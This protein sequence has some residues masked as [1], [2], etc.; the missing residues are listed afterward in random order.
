MTDSYKPLLP[1]TEVIVNPPIQTGTFTT[2]TTFKTSAGD[3]KRVQ[4]AARVSYESSIR[5]ATELMGGLGNTIREA[6]NLL[7]DDVSLGSI[8]E[9]TNKRIVWLN[10]VAIEVDYR[11]WLDDLRYL[12][13]IDLLTVVR[14]PQVAI[15]PSGQRHFKLYFELRGE[16]HLLRAVVDQQSDAMEKFDYC[17]YFQGRFAE[18]LPAD[19]EAQFTYWTYFRDRIVH[20]FKI[21]GDS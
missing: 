14:L 5:C 11:V 12:L 7:N 17:F 15:V 6:A 4:R 20:E 2:E 16:P 21:N 18:Q 1:I 19:D 13:P 8:Q 3:V 9:L 10:N